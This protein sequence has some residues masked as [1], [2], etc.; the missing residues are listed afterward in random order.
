M[1]QENT[2]NQIRRYEK[3]AKRQKK[4]VW[5]NVVRKLKSWK[6][7]ICML[8]MM[9]DKVRRGTLKRKKNLTGCIRDDD[10]SILMDEESITRR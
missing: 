2:S 5:R 9:H 10:G 7:E 6:R 1:T 8:C 3:C 4:N